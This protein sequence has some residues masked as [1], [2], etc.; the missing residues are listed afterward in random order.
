MSAGDSSAR[1]AG[2]LKGQR[3]VVNGGAAFPTPGCEWP[4][5]SA[6]PVVFSGSQSDDQQAIAKNTRMAMAIQFDRR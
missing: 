6:N 4:E 1:R 5:T 3:T 2:G